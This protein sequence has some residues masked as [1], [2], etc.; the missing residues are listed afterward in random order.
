MALIKIS[1]HTG[2]NLKDTVP[3]DG[4][5]TIRIFLQAGSQMFRPIDHIF[6]TRDLE[7]LKSEIITGMYLGRYPSDHS[8]SVTVVSLPDA[9]PDAAPSVPED[10]Y[11]EE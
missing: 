10:Q 5:S 3:S 6:V 4:P 8:P 11:E 1:E 2:L 7:V 9:A